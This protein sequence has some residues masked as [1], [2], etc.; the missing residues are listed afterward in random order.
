MKSKEWLFPVIL[1]VYHL[2]FAIIAWEYSQQHPSDAVRYWMLEEEWS[3]YLHWGTDVIKLISYPFSSVLQWPFWTGFL[4]YSLIGFFAIWEFYSFSL[5]YIKPSGKWEKGLLILIFLLPNLHFW[6]SV[7]GKEP[8]VFLAITWI[9]IQNSHRKYVSIKNILGWWLLT[10]VRQYH[11][12]FLPMAVLL[13]MLGDNRKWNCKKSIAIVASVLTIS[14][15]YLMTMHLLNR[16]PLDIAYILERNRASLVAFKRAGSYISMIDYNWIERVFALNFRPLFWDARSTYDFI[17]S[18][19]NLLVIVL[20]LTS[21]VVWVKN[22]KH[23]K[24]DF[25]AKISILFFVIAS[26]FYIQR[27]ACLG[28]FVRTKI[29]YL[30]FLLIVAI[31]IIVKTAKKKYLLIKKE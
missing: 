3:D 1:L 6:T 29:M 27:Y 23:I 16:N 31:K 22:A 10:S 11:A 28:I 15:L 12:R 13:G 5:R 19:E 14:G 7:I 8:V 2:T 24:W 17:L 25:F 20:L 30:P 21:V 18:V 4:L 9:I 26:L